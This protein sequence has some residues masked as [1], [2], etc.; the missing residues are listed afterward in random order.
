M[1]RYSL[2]YCLIA[3]CIICLLSACKKIHH[4][5]TPNEYLDELVNEKKAVKCG[6]DTYIHKEMLSRILPETYFLYLINASC[7]S[8]VYSFVSFYRHKELACET[9][10]CVVVDQDY[11]PNLEFYLEKADIKIDNKKLFLLPNTG[12]TLI[13]KSIEKANLNGL[14]FVIANGQ[15]EKQV[16]YTGS[17]VKFE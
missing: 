3:A 16:L 13:S 17:T 4:K 7:S 6:D 1:K 5:V 9:P 14:V 2:L 11:L 15:K 10:V 8:C 12:D